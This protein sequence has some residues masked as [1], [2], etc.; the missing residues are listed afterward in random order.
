MRPPGTPETSPFRTR[1]PT[2]SV[3]LHRPT[4]FP[5]ERSCICEKLP[6][7]TTTSHTVGD[8]VCPIALSRSCEL[9]ELR[10]PTKLLLQCVV[11]TVDTVWSISRCVEQ[12]ASVLCKSVCATGE[13]RRQCD[14]RQAPPRL[15]TQQFGLSFCT[16]CVLAS[17]ES[18]SE[19]RRRVR[20]AVFSSWLY[21]QLE[22][23]LS[24]WL[25]CLLPDDRPS[26]L[27]Q[28]VPS[29]KRF[30]I[31]CASSAREVETIGSCETTESPSLSTKRYKYD[32]SE[33]TS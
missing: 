14:S 11:I 16:V 29:C 12:K 27:R 15:D 1:P 23:L 3:E 4:T 31:C 13:P 8:G 6:L 18:E 9:C 10:A 32:S 28:S 7:Y 33:T 25:V 30:R 26:H 21:V 20:C 5:E 17:V 19:C 24:G 22:P 2:D